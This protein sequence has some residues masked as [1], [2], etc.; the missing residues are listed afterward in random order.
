V[1]RGGPGL[2]G[3]DRLSLGIA[4]LALVAQLALGGWVSTNYAVLA[5]TGFPTCNGHWWPAM[6]WSE[7]FTLMR[8]LGRRAD[9]QLISMSALVAIQWMHRLFA[10]VVVLALGWLVQ[11]L[12]RRGPDA[13]RRA[14]L[15][16]GLVVLQLG[17]GL[18][19]VVMGWPLS[20]ALLHTAGAAALVICLG[21]EAAIALQSRHR[22]LPS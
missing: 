3:R 2:D 19:N 18:S 16:A 1:E 13:Q 9:G 20:A 7:G 17:T 8:E 11:R 14:L 10:V 5:C 21:L 15:I 4:A 12:W 22:I 6:N